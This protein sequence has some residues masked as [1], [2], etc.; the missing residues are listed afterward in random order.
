MNKK[1][2][3]T[4]SNGFISKRL[5]RY[6][7]NKSYRVFSTSRFKSHNLYFDLKNDL[8]QIYNI[9]QFDILIHLAYFKDISFKKEKEY[10]IAGSKNIFL[11]A[12]K[13]NARIIYISSQ[14]ASKQSFSKYGKIKY[15]IEK[16]AYKNNACI[17]RPGLIYA[18]NS[19][20][21]I[22]GGIEKIIKNMPIIIVPK[23]LNKKINLCCIDT[24]NEKVNEILLNNNAKIINL[25]EKE[26][27]NIVD[28]VNYISLKN[29]KKK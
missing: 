24:F 9:P 15:E 2:L 5:K 25:Y 28:L 18:Q 21:G 1:I 27:Y 26:N 19:N 20:L 3:I 7:V 13:Y 23:G 29:K 11:L 16:I 12:K 22:Y 17:I 8:D 4:G 10:N 14:S 6:L